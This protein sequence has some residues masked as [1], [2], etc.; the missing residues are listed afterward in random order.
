MLFGERL[1]SSRYFPY[2]V[3][4]PLRI[5]KKTIPESPGVIA[6]GPTLGVYVLA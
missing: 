5:K 3:R 2:P 1:I 4:K 6:F